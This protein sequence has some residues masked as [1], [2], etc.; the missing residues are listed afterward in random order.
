MQCKQYVYND[1]TG[2]ITNGLW[3]FIQINSWMQLTT[4]INW[5]DLEVKR[6]KIKVRLTALSTDEMKPYR[7]W[8]CVGQKSEKYI[9]VNM[10]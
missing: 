9:S 5:L 1:L 4:K 2:Y 10:L 3:K 7:S 8:G 6:S